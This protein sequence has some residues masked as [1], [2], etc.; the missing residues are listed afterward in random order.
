MSDERL[1]ELR[2]RCAAALPHPSA[3]E[4][5]RDARLVVDA[6]LVDFLTLADKSVGRAASRAEME[7]RLHRPPPAQG[8][9]VADVLADFARDILP[10]TLRPHHPRFLAFIPG[11]PCW[12]AVLGDWLC[13]ATNAFAGVWLEASGPAEVELVVL[14]WF[15]TWAG[16]PE[17]TAG[18]LTGGGSEANLTALV[19]ARDA[20]PPADRGR[21]VLYVSA[22]RHWSIDRAARIIG[23]AAEQ[24]RPIAADE[25]WRMSPPALAA[26]AAADRG[27][28]RR[29]WAVVANAG[30][31]NTGAIDPLEA[32]AEICERQRL[33]LHV[34][35]A[36]GGA[37]ALSPRV[38]PQLAGIGRADSLTLD[39]H[40]WLAQP[41]EVGCLLVR[42]GRRLHESFAMRPEYMQDV[43]PEGDEV[44]FADR[45]IALTRRFRA[46]KV[47]FSLQVLGEGWFAALIDHGVSLARYAE[48][49]LRRAGFEVMSPARLSVVCFRAAAPG[50]AGE[51]L[52][53][54]N[55]ALVEAVRQS[56]E[57]FI[58]STRLGGRVA[59]RFC[60]VNWRTT[61]DDVDRAIALLRRS[62]PAAALTAPP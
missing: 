39:P 1:P 62:Q 24:V 9:P 5:R 26:A 30:A 60:F 52:D 22:Q 17:T 20:L 21:A 61:A 46:L 4:R 35:G 57:A 40:K 32:L 3:D 7:A 54:V 55:L 15:R 25:A 48:A 16:L 51:G 38:R 59:L 13:A 42:D 10:F 31:T 29:P 12:P 19:V 44:N 11:A 50:L 45:G 43:V 18:V 33:W 56:G 36:Y 27:A 47:W 41:F 37:A 28:G 6:A 8:R 49:A 34:D 14:D 53:R 58:S 2:A 23:L